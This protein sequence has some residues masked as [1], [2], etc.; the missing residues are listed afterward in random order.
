[1]GLIAP[2]HAKYVHGRRVKTLASHL[3][4]LIPQQSSVLDVGSG[5]G[6]LAR[7]LLDLRPDL[8]L[9]GVDI[10]VRP[11]THIPVIAYDGF[12]L[13][14]ADHSIDV[15]TIMDV[16]HHT[17]DPLITMREA[18]RVAK[19]A[20]IIKDHTSSGFIGRP[21]LKFMD[22]V[23][24]ARHGV[25]S[26][27][28]YWTLHQWNEAFVQLGTSTTSWKTELGLYPWWANWLFGDR[29][30]FITSLSPVTGSIGIDNHLQ[31]LVVH[32]SQNS[33]HS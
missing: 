4:A 27:G 16:L 22:W 18:L 28:N 15:V 33:P 19:Q 5:D 6:Q 30:H 8:Q 20:V 7:L 23:G 2:I 31:N 25:A 14:H 13:P 32:S 29:L 26:P 3:A 21:L 1:M 9:Q 24:N 12:H 17:E 10:K 11:Q